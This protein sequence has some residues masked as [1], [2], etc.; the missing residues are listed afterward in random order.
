MRY[1]RAPSSD[2]FEMIAEK[3]RPNQIGIDLD[4]FKHA[5]SSCLNY[6]IQVN[7]SYRSIDWETTDWDI[8]LKWNQ[9]ALSHLVQKIKDAKSFDDL[10]TG[11]WSDFLSVFNTKSKL[12]LL[13]DSLKLNN[14][15]RPENAEIF[16]FSTNMIEEMACLFYCLNLTGTNVVFG[17]DSNFA[18]S[19][20]ICTQ[21]SS[22]QSYS[23]YLGSES[24][25]QE[26]WN[27]KD[28]L[29][30]YLRLTDKN[31][32]SEL[33]K[34]IWL[35]FLNVFN[36]SSKIEMLH[37]SLVLNDLMDRQDSYSFNYSQSIIESM[38]YIKK[39]LSRVDYKERT[40]S[41][42]ARSIYLCENYDINTLSNS[43]WHQ[44]NNDLQLDKRL[45]ESIALQ[46]SD[47]ES[48]PKS[49]DFWMSLTGAFNTK[50]KLDLLTAS[51]TLQDTLSENCQYQLGLQKNILTYIHTLHEG[52][53]MNLYRNKESASIEFGIA[54][55]WCVH[56]DANTPTKT[57][58][59]IPTWN[60][61]AYEMAER[62]LTIGL[63]IP[64]KG[65]KF[66]CNLHLIFDS[67]EKLNKLG[68]ALET[69]G[70]FEKKDRIDLQSKKNILSAI[71]CIS[72]SIDRKLRSLDPRCTPPRLALAFENAIYSNT[73]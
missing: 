62:E 52:I 18:E 36:S 20:S 1:D 58:P 65:S 45:I 54:L 61:E 31:F 53:E 59:A 2:I 15:I 5:I 4:K 25:N 23:D 6:D 48:F 51:L 67:Q 56:F 47:T 7:Y 63:S 21:F 19:V 43:Q 68:F 72:N 50:E 29:R 27:R 24:Q 13:I 64:R 22:V 17:S 44:H 11:V 49:A 16:H 12:K 55:L 41:D 30:L 28:M 57:G 33:G 40:L 14:L 8:E 60:L 69:V 9:E 3:L 34:D 35:D 37:A 32:F 26:L 71:V 46:V 10:T 73:L 66:W 39:A 38:I 42:V 70:I